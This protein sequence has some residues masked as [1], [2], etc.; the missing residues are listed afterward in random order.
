MPH[1]PIP[2]Y[3]SQEDKTGRESVKTANRS[4]QD[5]GSESAVSH[6]DNLGIKAVKELE[7]K[8]HKS[9]GKIKRVSKYL[10]N[11]KDLPNQ[12]DPTADQSSHEDKTGR[13]SV[14]TTNKSTQDNGFESEETDDDATKESM[15][16]FSTGEQYVIKMLE[17]EGE[18]PERDNEITKRQDKNNK[19]NQKNF[20]TQELEND[21]KR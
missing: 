2:N 13:E 14:K 20:T 10:K 17:I 5:N 21:K 15:N 19:E 1:V 9:E 16:E 4:T 3:S 12:P 18:N 8:I 6:E 7:E 11:R